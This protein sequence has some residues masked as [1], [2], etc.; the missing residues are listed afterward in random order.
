Q[1]AA[2]ASFFAVFGTDPPATPVETGF[3]IWVTTPSDLVPIGGTAPATV[4]VRNRTAQ[5]FAGAIGATWVHLGDGPLLWTQ[6]VRV[7]AGEEASFPVEYPVVSLGHFTLLYGLFESTAAFPAAEFPRRAVAYAAKGFAPFSPSANVALVA[8]GTLLRPGV[9]LPVT[10]RAGSIAPRSFDADLVLRLLSP[11]N[12]ELW[13]ETGRI[14]LPAARTSEFAATILTTDG[15]PGPSLLVAEIRAGGSVAGRGILVLEQ[16]PFALSV[17]PALPEPWNP[18]QPAVLGFTVRNE[19]IFATP[20]GT[21]RAALANSRNMALWSESADLPGLA[22]GAQATVTLSVAALDLLFGDYRLRYAAEVPGGRFPGSRPLANAVNVDLAAAPALAG[23][24]DTLRAEATVS[25]TGSFAVSGTLALDGAGLL[26]PATEMLDLVPGSLVRRHYSALVTE[27]TPLGNHAL[28]AAFRAGGTAA[29]AARVVVPPA[30]LDYLPAPAEVAAGE[31]LALTAVNTGRNTGTFAWSLRLLPVGVDPDDLAAVPLARAAASVRLESAASAELA[32]PVPAGLA[33]GTYALAA[34]AHDQLS[35]RSFPLRAFVFVRGLAAALTVAP[36]RPVYARGEP[37]TAAASAVNAGPRLPGAVLEL[38][39]LGAGA[40]EPVAYDGTVLVSPAGDDALGDGSAA[41]P[42]ATPQRGIDAAPAGFRVLLLA[43]TYAQNVVLRPGTI[44]QGEVVA[45]EPAAVIADADVVGAANTAVDHLAVHNGS[46]V[47]P[48][49]VADA[50]VTDCAFAGGARS[51]SPRGQGIV[52]TRAATRVLVGRNR[53][54]GFRSGSA[55]VQFLGP[56]A[57]VLVHE[58]VLSDISGPGNSGLLLWDIAERITVQGNAF[59]ALAGGGNGVQVWGGAAPVRALR[60]LNNR[61]EAMSGG[62]NGVHVWG[63]SEGMEVRGNTFR[64]LDGDVGGIHLWDATVSA[65]LSDNA[66]ETLRGDATGIQLW[67]SESPHRDV[68]IENNRLADIEPLDAMAADNGIVLWDVSERVTVARNELERVTGSDR[69]WLSSGIVVNAGATAL[70]IERNVVRDGLVGIALRPPAPGP[71]QPVPVLE[72]VTLANNLLAGND[73]GFLE[74]G[75]RPEDTV[76][77]RDG[78]VVSSLRAGILTLGA[79]APGGVAAVRHTDLFANARDAEGRPAPAAGE[80][81]ITADPLLADLAH[82]DVRLLPGSPCID[83]GSQPALDI[84]PLDDDLAIVLGPRPV[85]PAAAAGV[86]WQNTST[87]DLEVGASCDVEAPVEPLDAAGSLLLVGR[88]TN[89]AGQTL[90]EDVAAFTIQADPV[91]LLLTA[92]RETFRAGESVPVALQVVNT[93][94]D[95]INDLLVRVTQEGSEV[96]VQTLALDPGARADLAF[97]TRAARDTV[98]HAVA[99]LAAAD[100]QIRIAAVAVTLD[101]AAPALAGDEPFPLAALV[102]NAGPVPADLRLAFAGAQ[103]DFTLA[104][105][106][107]RAFR[108]MASIVQDTVFVARLTGDATDAVSHT[109]RYGPRLALRLA[110]P[111]T[112]AEGPA[113]ATLLL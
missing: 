64:E 110:V 41:R 80:G 23:D 93:G 98:L 6:D 56:A 111:E 19:G 50:R 48:D 53:I 68:R 16:P 39:V 32:L 15:E 22:P 75:L 112:L 47:Y 83:G 33:A 107:Q 10:I 96:F 28:S 5:D 54:A 3:Q 82:G 12:R 60:V 38:A 58:N 99:G 72:A 46:V 113:S 9:P 67:E 2:N 59:S 57:D 31:T 70:T 44:L 36:G 78:I 85:A 65:N 87:V 17:L 51:V 43:G 66:L 29:A 109:V 52:F 34:D 106:E 94:G 105:G 18:A 1:T 13:A 101:L 90:A 25:N 81:N 27:T 84:G 88:L 86:H 69:S 89:A 108:R 74:E 77:F 20:A 79:A 4:H 30:R 37:V 21:L 104:P 40:I 7:P 102:A 45:G 61:F 8:P 92:P 42:F 73:V 91:Q 76:T 14:T 100:L 26:P 97:A 55:G 11:S 62:C 35:S 103:A 49:D 63:A 24:G 71:Y 95:A